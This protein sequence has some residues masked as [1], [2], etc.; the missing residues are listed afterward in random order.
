[1]KL[2]W[3]SNW[4]AAE[5]R[6]NIPVDRNLSAITF[7]LFLIVEILKLNHNFLV[8]RIFIFKNSY[9]Q[10][11]VGN[12]VISEQNNLP[13]TQLPIPSCTIIK[14][15]PPG[16]PYKRGIS[17]KNLKKLLYQISSLSRIVKITL[18]WFIFWYNS[19]QW[20][21]PENGF[22]NFIHRFSSL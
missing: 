12:F 15:L 21:L 1:M 8:M 14:T 20:A 16:S 4:K 22:K 3:A 7:E 2:R 18:Q 17:L 11:G 5:S 10:W 6:P 13:I 9:L 19:L